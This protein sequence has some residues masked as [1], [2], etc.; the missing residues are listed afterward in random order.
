MESIANNDE[1]LVR[2]GVPALPAGEEQQEEEEGNVVVNRRDF[3]H[4]A[5]T[6]LDWL[7]Q[8]SIAELDARSCRELCERIGTVLSRYQEQPGLLDP[9]MERLVEP[10]V[11]AMSKA[12]QG[13]PK[14]LLKAMPNLHLLTSLLYLLTMIRGYK[15]VVRLFPHEA[16][17]LE[18]CLEAAEAEAAATKNAGGA[19]DT[20]STLY[21]LTLWLGMVVLTPF[22]LRSIDS[23]GSE[24]TA[25]SGARLAD[26]ILKL[27][28]EGLGS[29]SRVRDASAWMLA[30]FFSRPDVSNERVLKEFCE[31]TKQAC[32]VDPAAECFG[33]DSANSPVAVSTFALCGALQAWSQTLKVAGRDAVSEFWAD[34]VEIALQSGDLVK[35]STTRKLKVKVAYRAALAALPPRVA[36]WRYQRGA[37]SLAL[38]SLANNA[39]FYASGFGSSVAAQDT[40]NEE[41]EEEDVPEQIEE[42]IETLLDALKDADTVVRWAAAKGVGRVTNRLSRD[43]ADQVLESLMERCFS[44]RETDKA[45]HGGCLALAELTRRGL[46]LPARLPTVVPLVCQAL[47]FEHA[48]GNFAVGQHVRDAA[49][50]VSWAFARAYAP[51]ILQPFVAEL[52]R[53]LIQVA[54]Y[55]REVNCRRAAAA[56]V[57]EQVGRQGTFPNGID[58]VTIA[59]Y[60]TI[61]VCR[62]SYLV[63]APQIAHIGEYR[64]CLVDH[65]V[66]R[67]LQHQD[68]QIRILASKGLAKLAEEASDSTLVY[69]NEHVLPA[70]LDRALGQSKSEGRDCGPAVPGGPTGGTVAARHGAVMAVAAV[71]Q[72]LQGSVAIERQTSIRNLVPALEKARAYRGRGGEIVRQAACALLSA[73]AAATTWPFKEATAA[74]Y[75]QTIDECVRHTTDVVQVSAA[76]ALRSL[77][78][79]RFGAE[80]CRKCA[81]NYT[82]GLRK[83]GETIAARRGFTLCLGMLPPRLLG[84]ALQ[85]VVAALTKEVTGTSLPGGEEQQDPKTRQYAV[86]SLGSL[87]LSGSLH[88]E[89]LAQALDALEAAM[90]DYATDRRGDVGSWVREAATEVIAAILDAQRQENPTCAL[91]DTGV[92]TRLVGHLLRQAVEK[93]DRLR[94]RA[95]GLLQYL[96]CDASRDTCMTVDKAYRRICHGEQYALPQIESSIEEAK[97]CPTQAWSVSWPPARANTLAKQLRQLAVILWQEEP[98]PGSSQTP[99]PPSREDK[100]ADMFR[101]LVPLAVHDEYRCSIISG[102]VVSVGGL[103]AHTAKDAQAALMSFLDDGDEQRAENVVEVLLD[104][105]KQVNVKDGDPEARRVLPPLLCMVGL[106]L[107][108]GKVPD[109]MGAALCTQARQVVR[110]SKDMARLRSSISVF[111]GLLGWKGT[112]RISSLSVLLQFLGYSFPTIRQATANA[113]YIRLMEEEGDFDMSSPESGFHHTVT[114]ATLADLLE[115]ISVTPWSTDDTSLLT[116]ALHNAYAS[117]GLELPTSGRSILVPRKPAATVKSPGNEYADLVRENHY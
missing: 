21:C 94:D 63:V 44:F 32:C 80:A 76:D 85:T 108:H 81:D 28:R 38:A 109:S 61:S 111:V 79:H 82:S 41:V 93:I 88:V 6:V 114:S 49:C 100:N 51:D 34:L 43:F 68:V 99:A 57:Q 102:L 84:D 87:C 8:A 60:W 36:S 23:G 48:L 4:E 65:L 112:V 46:L 73:V 29:S 113:L 19:S 42:V 62:H 35:S 33:N 83:A 71:V 39:P 17:D 96:L 27:G 18:P 55:D 2:G 1:Q 31:W 95:C 101:A 90:E 5:D 67:K 7:K 103:T 110:S 98:P 106:L 3:F 52:A 116:E 20:W 107:S 117:F 22:D 89:E 40:Q 12:V 74:R 104:T 53:A 56:A 105:F 72:S 97:M 91:A 15:T 66:D 69:M 37:R 25:S 24:S 54:V 16:A 59:D 78:L 92:T 45:W 77:A 86:L 9:F 70:L 75:L 30:K 11:G 14:A 50:Y 115:L 64:R 13:D 47:H 10:L 58:V 26:R